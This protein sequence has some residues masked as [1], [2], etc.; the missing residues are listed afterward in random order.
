MTRRY[1]GPP[2]RWHGVVLA[3]GAA[4]RFGRDKVFATVGGRRLIDAA[5][6]SLARSDGRSVLL[7]TRERADAVANR[8]PDGVDA[9]PDDHP[10]HGPMGGLATALARHPDGW[11]AVL[12]AD[13][14][15]VPTGWWP[16]LAGQHVAGAA[17]I[18]PR[19]QR[20]RWEPLAALYHGSLG[21][22]LTTAVASGDPAR[23]GFQR[24]L[25]ALAT[26]GRVEA[27]DP[28]PMGPSALLNVNRP[29][30]AAEVERLLAAP[31]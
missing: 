26:D 22:A 8:L 30:D 7:G 28:T 16:W 9:L 23:L 20:G 4:R 29:E 11:T 24:W 2:E 18:V 15:L 10:G 3:G 25:D 31:G 6:A 12:A 19:D 1:V 21:A 27:V 14:P 17:A 13:L 5:L